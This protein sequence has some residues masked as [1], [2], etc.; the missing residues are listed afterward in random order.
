MERG[1][2]V[3][4]VPRSAQALAFEDN[5]EQVFTKQP[6]TVHNPGGSQVVGGFER[7]FSEFFERYF[8]QSFMRA[9]GLDKRLRNTSAFVRG[10]NQG[11]KRGKA[12]GNQVGYRWIAGKDG[13]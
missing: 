11:K 4:V 10:F 1:I 2:S 8:S 7:T 5:G 9:S 12:Y 13:I 6:V 3:T